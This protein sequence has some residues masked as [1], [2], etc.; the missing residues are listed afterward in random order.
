MVLHQGFGA[1]D[2]LEVKRLNPKQRQGK[3]VILWRV[4]FVPFFFVFGQER[5]A[6]DGERRSSSATTA[7]WLK[8]Y[9]CQVN[10]AFCCGFRHESGA[11]DRE[12]RRSKRYVGSTL[13]MWC[14][15]LL[16]R[17]FIFDTRGMRGGG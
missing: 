5:R 9:W 3:A 6:G 10:G 15:F 14:L 16:R 1:V 13:H 12:L 17:L 2:A 7:V 8:L 11:G 4:F